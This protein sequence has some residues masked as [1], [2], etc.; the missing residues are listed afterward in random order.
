MTLKIQLIR[1][2]KTKGNMEK[3]FTGGKTDEPLCS[4][5]FL[6]LQTLAKEKIYSAPGTLFASPLMRC[7]QTAEI[8]FLKKPA[9]IIEDFREIDFGIFENKN[10]EELN[11]NADYQKWIDSNGEGLIPRGENMETFRKR[12]MA[13]FNQMLATANAENISAV[14]H[15]G[16]IMAILSSLN[17]G[18]Y[19]DYFCKNGRGYV[20]EYSICENRLLSLRKI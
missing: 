19:Y 16:T 7:T 12:V 2:G 8:I 14:V 1:H 6:E 9:T 13:G 20:I 11:G 10:H 3:R 4:Q 18:N 15:G 17:G 5:G